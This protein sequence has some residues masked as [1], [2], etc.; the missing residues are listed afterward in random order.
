MEIPFRRLKAP[1]STSPQLAATWLFA[2]PFFTAGVAKDSAKIQGRPRL[3]HRRV[4]CC[5]LAAT[6]AAGNRPDVYDRGRAVT[7][8]LCLPDIRVMA[9]IRWLSGSTTGTR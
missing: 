5:C 4:Y 1:G 7:Y 9:V 8:F 2:L 6:A 3:A